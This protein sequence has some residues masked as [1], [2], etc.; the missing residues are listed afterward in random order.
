MHKYFLNSI[1]DALSNYFTN[2]HDIHNYNTRQSVGLYIPKVSTTL[3]KNS[4]KFRGPTI[5]NEIIKL[6]INLDIS[7]ATFSHK[8]KIIIKAGIL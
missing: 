8:V 5:W 7:E 4:I 6:N 3:A 2:V 1:P